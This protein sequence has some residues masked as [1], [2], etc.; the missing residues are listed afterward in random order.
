MLAPTH[1][2]RGCLSQASCHATYYGKSQQPWRCHHIVSPLTDSTGTA[3][4][5]FVHLLRPSFP[6]DITKRKEEKLQGD[7]MQMNGPQRPRNGLEV[8]AA[9]TY[10]GGAEAES[11]AIQV[12]AVPL[13]SEQDN[14]PDGTS[15][16]NDVF[17]GDDEAL[18]DDD[19]SADEG[20]PCHEGA[21]QKGAG[22]SN[23]SSTCTMAGCSSSSASVEVEVNIVGVRPPVG[24][25]TH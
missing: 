19:A 25:E 1:L 13:D 11:Q 9:N 20:S 2:R 18:A 8:S 22:H 16:N 6:D 4:H 23:H 24:I 21:Q 14:L 7:G 5:Y 12:R 15:S 3:S 17:S 10:W